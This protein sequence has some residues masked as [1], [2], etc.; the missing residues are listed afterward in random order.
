MKRTNISLRD[1]QH[2]W[3]RDLC[4]KERKGI[5][6]YFRLLISIQ[7]GSAD[8]KK[9]PLPGSRND[10]VLYP[11]PKP[12]EKETQEEVIE[13]ATKHGFSRPKEE[14]LK[15][16]YNPTPKPVQGRGKQKK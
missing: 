4:H 1:E 8:Q 16:S 3:V 5:S 13:Y 9:K 6:E 12:Q 10:G 11:Y 14:T 2:E 7:M 15:Q